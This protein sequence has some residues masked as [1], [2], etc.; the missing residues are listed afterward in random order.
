MNLK[1]TLVIGLCSVGLVLGASASSIVISQ[2]QDD[3]TKKKEVSQKDEKKET[4]DKKD[5]KK[6]PRK[7]RK[8]RKTSMTNC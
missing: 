5:E 2:Y 7:R 3:N 1:S 4:K 8:K 6:I